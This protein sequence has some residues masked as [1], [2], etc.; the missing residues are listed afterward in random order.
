MQNLLQAEVCGLQVPST[1]YISIVFNMLIKINYEQKV[2]NLYR[3]TVL[4]IV[5]QKVKI[6]AKRH[7]ESEIAK[8]SL[9][10]FWSVICF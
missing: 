2:D 3:C 5:T 6:S 7:L 1:M 9:N 8:Y 10:L 4:S